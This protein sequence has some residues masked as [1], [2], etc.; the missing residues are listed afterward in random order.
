MNILSTF[1]NMKFSK[2]IGNTIINETYSLVE[3]IIFEIDIK[4]II[5]ATKTIENI[6]V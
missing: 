5:G 3:K 1:E 2:I 4:Y 6:I